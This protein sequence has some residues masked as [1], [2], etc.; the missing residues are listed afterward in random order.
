MDLIVSNKM[1]SMYRGTIAL[2]TDENFETSIGFCFNKAY[3]NY[4]PDICFLP[5]GAADVQKAVTYCKDNKLSIKVKSAGHNAA[6]ASAANS[7]ALI[8]LGTYYVLVVCPTSYA[9]LIR[10]LFYFVSSS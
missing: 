5:R 9:A 2:P 8:N 6:G 4:K 10:M 3:A 1:R 7:G